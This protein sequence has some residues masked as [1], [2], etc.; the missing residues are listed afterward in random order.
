MSQ[1]IEQIENTYLLICTS[2]DILSNSPHSAFSFSFPA[3]SAELWEEIMFCKK[4]LNQFKN[5]Q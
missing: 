1:N 4:P 3:L 2:V 5:P